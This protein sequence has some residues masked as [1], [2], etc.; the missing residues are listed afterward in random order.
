MPAGSCGNCALIGA[1]LNPTSGLAVLFV[2]DTARFMREP[3][4]V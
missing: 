2:T 3:A 4:G 1:T